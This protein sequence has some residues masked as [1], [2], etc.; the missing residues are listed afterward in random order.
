MCFGDVGEEE[1]EEEL[2]ECRLKEKER[3][4]TKEEDGGMGKGKETPANMSKG[5][6]RRELEMVEKRGLIRPKEAAVAR[7]K[8]RICRPMPMG[9]IA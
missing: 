8:L 6:G 5:W 4:E 3:D 9:T 2:G 1:Q 7:P